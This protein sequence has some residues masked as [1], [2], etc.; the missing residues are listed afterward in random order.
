MIQEIEGLKTK[1]KFEAFGDGGCL[2]GAEVEANV[3]GSAQDAAAGVTENLLRSWGGDGGDVPP[4]EELLGT[5]VG[6]SN[7]VAVVLLK[8]NDI[9]GVI[10]GG[11]TGCRQTCTDDADTSDLP[12]AQEFFLDAGPP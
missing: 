2:H 6:I 3:L 8:G 5:S 1:L 11:E 12:S 9:G 4:I 7:D 10:V